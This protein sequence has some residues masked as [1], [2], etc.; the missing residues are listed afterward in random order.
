M[1]AFLS[2]PLT[3]AI[4]TQAV[5]RHVGETEREDASRV[6]VA[7]DGGEPDFRLLEFLADGDL[8]MLRAK[9]DEFITTCENEL[10]ALG[11]AISR[12]QHA[13]FYP[14]AHRFLGQ[15]RFVGAAPLAAL[16]ERMQFLP[17]DATA[18]EAAQLFRQLCAEFDL[19]RCKLRSYLDAREN[20]SGRSRSQT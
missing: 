6:A 10:A 9:A 8:A 17:A 11:A 19:V 12:Q 2:K 20:S 16:A 18:E 15:S 13:E 14:R 3:P 5:T 4:I 1:D 7:E